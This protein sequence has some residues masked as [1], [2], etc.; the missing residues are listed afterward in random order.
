MLSRED[1]T[2][3][4]ALTCFVQARAQ[5]RIDHSKTILN[6]IHLT[7]Q[8]HEKGYDNIVQDYFSEHITYDYVLNH[9]IENT[10]TG[11][12]IAK[13]NSESSTKTGILL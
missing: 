1:H 3:L 5:S 4:S 7:M 9:T 2:N 12:R 13:P 6:I 10:I 8:S 11:R